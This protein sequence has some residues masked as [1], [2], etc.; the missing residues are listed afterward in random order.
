MRRDVIFE[1]KQ[2]NLSKV[3]PHFINPCCFGE[4]VAAWMG[5]H[6]RKQGIN[7]TPPAQEDWGWYFLAEMDGEQY[8]LGIG[9][10]SHENPNDPDYGEWRIMI[11]KPQSLWQKLTRKNDVVG[12]K[13]F[14]QMIEH[15]LIHEPGI[16]SIRYE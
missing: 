14:F 2:F 11:E 10:N 13:R 3:Q 16:T 1:S 8:F 7:A 6:L 4:D 9:G 15:L 5:D 12:S